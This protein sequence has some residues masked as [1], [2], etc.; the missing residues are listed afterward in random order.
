MN[1]D[2][3]RARCVLSG[4]PL[5]IA[6]CF[7]A[8]QLPLCH[9]AGSAE[10][11]VADDDFGGD[12]V[13]SGWSGSSAARDNVAQDVRRNIPPNLL[14]QDGEQQP[15]IEQ[16]ETLGHSV[17]H[18][19]VLGGYGL[20][21][22]NHSAANELGD[23]DLIVGIFRYQRSIN[24]VQATY[25]QGEGADSF[26]C[27]ATEDY[28]FPDS[29][30]CA[31]AVL[32]QPHI[33]Y[34]SLVAERRW[35]LE[36]LSAPVLICVEGSRQTRF[37]EIFFGRVTKDDVAVACGPFWTDRAEVY[38]GE[39]LRPM[40]V[41][42]VYTARPGTLVCVM[43]ENANCPQLRDLDAM[44]HTPLRWFTD[45]WDR[46]DPQDINPQTTIGMIGYAANW[47]TF[48]EDLLDDMEA[49]ESALFGEHVGLNRDCRFVSPMR[50]PP[51]VSFRGKCV[52]H[53]IGVVPASL[54]DCNVVFLDARDL[55]C[56]LQ[57]IMLPRVP[58]SIDVLLHLAGAVRP[59]RRLAVKGAQAYVPETGFFR[60]QSDH[61]DRIAPSEG[62][63]VGSHPTDKC[64]ELEGEQHSPPPWKASR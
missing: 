41:E 46:I 20:A 40:T 37:V 60:R 3:K 45:N 47:R 59:N 31:F 14:P 50:R 11:S 9:A 24:F 5:V 48:D 22:E 1:R 21:T 43:P 64:D 4:A 16:L 28:A 17:E 32:P 23:V 63:G 15:R 54:Q 10:A 34:V 13:G 62:D 56:P 26:V 6:C 38:W 18:V 25:E 57:M 49:L 39:S 2:I 30:F 27:F 35:I 7:V 36:Q 12:D 55:G 42:D 51:D 44:L 58:T 53:V 29:E 8:Y 19:D 52:G 61:D 33:G